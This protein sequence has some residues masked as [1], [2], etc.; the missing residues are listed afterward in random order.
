V[1]QTRL[2]EYW[3]GRL[4]ILALVPDAFGGHGGIALYNRDFLKAL[5]SH[6]AVSEVVA[7]PRN[8]PH[9]LEPLPEKLTYVIEA[10]GGKLRYVKALLRL[11]FSWRR[12]D[13]IVCG[14]MNLLPLAFFLRL[15]FRAPILLEIYGIEAWRPTGRRM[16]DFLARRVQAVM[17]ISDITKDKF[18]LWSGYAGPAIFVLPNAIH[19]ELYGMA[20]KNPSLLARY[21]LH[22]KTVL[23]T[24]GR[25]DAR[26]KYKGFDEVLEAL[27]AL[28]SRM[29]D[30][31]YLIVGGGTDHQRLVHKAS[32]LGV[33]ERVVFAG[34]I[35][36]AEKADHYRLADVYV[37]PSRG[38]GFGFVF[39]EAMAC[40]VPVVAS[41]VDG[42]REA[43]RDGEL[44]G[45]VE[46]GNT[47]ELIAA[48]EQALRAPREVPAGLAYFDFDNFKRRTQQFISKLLKPAPVEPR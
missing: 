15:R 20:G 35:P 11:A 29:S 22:G 4:R 41:R 24:L 25:I 28:S 33:G 7:L 47:T 13:L 40:G 16:P 39:L 3:D 12:I 30:V 38:E 19:P 44:G 45:L 21:G 46:P 36:E 10:A 34:M 2:R 5:C 26:E 14:H 27:P 1:G 18:S 48:I 43:V 31:A 23:M 17:S 37:M 8:A 9:A 42:S 32:E 6:P